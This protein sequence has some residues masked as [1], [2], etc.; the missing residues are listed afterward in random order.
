MVKLSS[1]IQNHV[2]TA[3]AKS[4][5]SIPKERSALLVSFLI[6]PAAGEES[7]RRGKKACSSW[8]RTGGRSVAETRALNVTQASGMIITITFMPERP[9]CLAPC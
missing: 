4:S 5:R 3:E 2:A 1:E 7:S 9:R 6:P 8:L